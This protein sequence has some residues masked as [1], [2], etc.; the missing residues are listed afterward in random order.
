MAIKR[1]INVLAAVI[2]L[3]GC[4]VAAKEV[5][6]IVLKIGTDII[7]QAGADYIGKILSP[8]DAKGHPTLVVSHTN[9]AGEGVGADYALGN[10][11]RITTQNVTIRN[12]TGDIHIVGDGNGIAV[13]VASG[14]TATI[15]INSASIAGAV[16][17]A[18]DGADDQAATIDGILGW[19]GRSRRALFSALDDLG[20]CRNVAGATTALENVADDRDHQIG[21][22]DNID[23][24]ALPGGGSL[25]NTLLRA[26]NYSVKA[27]QAF[28]R[29]GDAQQN[30]CGEDDNYDEAMR[31]SR[32]AT[33]TKQQFVR[34]WNPVARTY[35]LPELEEPDI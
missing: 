34:K 7:V 12:I 16:G 9:A 32:S 10:A 8:D 6:E 2:L 3:S 33:A 24:S 21:A 20:A 22:L 18:T 4:G 28:V 25:R 23:V 31:Y 15:A 5:G 13:T 29:W 35:G 26:L 11:D 17:N 27:D 30:G 19:S 1:T 14:A